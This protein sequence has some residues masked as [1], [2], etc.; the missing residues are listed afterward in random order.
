M[1][2]LTGKAPFYAAILLFVMTALTLY[3]RTHRPSNSARSGST[4]EGTIIYDPGAPTF[5][6]P[7][8]ALVSSN[9]PFLNHSTPKPF[10]SYLQQT[11]DYTHF[12]DLF[13]AIN[14]T[15]GTLQTRGEAHVTVV[16]PPEFDRALKPAGVTIKEI[17]EI[18][19]RNNIQKARL[20]PVC[21]GRFNGTLPN[22]SKAESDKGAFI[23]FS[24][25]VA[26]VYGDLVNIRREV[27][28]LYRSKGG[29]G[30]LFQPEGFWP[31]ITIGFDRR[32]LFIEDGLYKGSNY[33]YAPIRT[34][35]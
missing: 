20:M 8:Q 29:Q 6:L 17:E 30:A 34:S 4:T 15:V 10:Q 18:A 33:C 7:A 9:I 25:V 31:H 21:L 2:S 27:F 3:A 19:L 14:A 5:H 24:L 22:P 26:D 28:K 12:S 23:L 11:L 32:D 1:L 13:A 35:K 16:T